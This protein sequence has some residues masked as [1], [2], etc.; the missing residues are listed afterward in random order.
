MVYSEELAERIRPNLLTR[1]DVRE[2]S[3]FGG[4]A[5]LVN[6]NMCIGLWKDLLVIRLSK[7]EGAAALKEPHVRI[8]DLTGRPMRGWIFVEPAG[9]KAD[10]DLAHW[11]ERAYSFASSLPAKIKK[12]KPGK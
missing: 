5:F 1:T 12:P 8:M 7:E 11:V 4:I 3:M 2:R 6:G 10:K 9:F